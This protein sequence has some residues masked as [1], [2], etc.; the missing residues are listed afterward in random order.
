MVDDAGAFTLLQRFARTL[1]RQYDLDDVLSD[2]AGELRD[3]LEV[4]GAGG[5]HDLR[6]K[7]V[8]SD[9]FQELG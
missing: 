5:G 2:L 7:M 9:P 1:V 8:F 3:V 6:A 4:A